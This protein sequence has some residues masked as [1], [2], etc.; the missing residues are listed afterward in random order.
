MPLSKPGK[1]ERYAFEI[2]LDACVGC[3]ACV[4]ACHSLNGLDANELWRNVGMIT[5]GDAAAPFQQTVT[6]TC[7]HCAE[8]AAWTAALPSP[9]IKTRKPVLCATSTTNVSAANTAC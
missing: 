9:T 8:P 3:K 7:H 5:S 1:G 2:G 6:T 4:V